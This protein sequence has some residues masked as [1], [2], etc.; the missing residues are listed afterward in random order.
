MLLPESGE[1]E[2]VGIFRVLRRKVGEL[3]AF[4]THSAEVK[5]FIV[6]LLIRKIY[7]TVN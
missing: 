1:R 2:K 4:A 6:L 7:F 3:S 5:M